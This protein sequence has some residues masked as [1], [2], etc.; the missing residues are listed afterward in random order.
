M[1]LSSWGRE[2]IFHMGVLTSAFR[3]RE[4]QNDLFASAVLKVFLTQNSPYTNVAY[5]VVMYSASLRYLLLYSN[6]KCNLN[7]FNAVPI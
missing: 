7:C 6:G 2:D 4:G 5:F 1:F 3:K